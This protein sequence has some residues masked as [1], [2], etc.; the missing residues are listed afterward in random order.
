MKVNIGFTHIYPNLLMNDNIILVH[1]FE[2]A[3]ICV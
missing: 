1:D 2:N 3:Y